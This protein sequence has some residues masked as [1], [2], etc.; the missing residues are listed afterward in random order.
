M[1]LPLKY[2]TCRLHIENQTFSMWFQ[3]PVNKKLLK[4][5]PG[6]TLVCVNAC[7]PQTKKVLEYVQKHTAV[8]QAHACCALV[9]AFIHSLV[10]L[11]QHGL[12]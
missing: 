6:N 9:Q 5:G 11:V 12:L 7:S 8:S 4:G 2:F 1:R 10:V 3:S